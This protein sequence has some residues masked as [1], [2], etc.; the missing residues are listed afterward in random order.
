MSQWSIDCIVTS[1]VLMAED[2]RY[3]RQCDALLVDKQFFRRVL[4]EDKEGVI[5]E[6][7]D[8]LE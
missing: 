4:L 3:D 5:A 6:S 8:F 7:G 2:S 1:L